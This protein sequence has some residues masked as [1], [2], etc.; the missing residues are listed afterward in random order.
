MR[1]TIRRTFACS[2]FSRVTNPGCSSGDIVANGPF[3]A[4]SATN[5]SSRVDRWWIQPTMPCA[6]SRSSATHSAAAGVPGV[7]C[8]IAHSSAMVSSDAAMSPG[9]RSDS[10]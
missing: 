3:S 10:L 2:V 6:R 7:S 8:A 4:R 5:T 1:S 9:R